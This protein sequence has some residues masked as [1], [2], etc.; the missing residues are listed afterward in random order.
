MYYEISE[1]QLP[2]LLPWNGVTLGTKP[3]WYNTKPGLELDIPGL[4]VIEPVDDRFAAT[5]DYEYYCLL[6]KLSHYDDDIPHELH[7]IV[8]EDSGT[9]KGPHLF[10]ERFDVGNDLLS[11][12]QVGMR[13]MR[14]P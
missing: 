11:R 6:S 3:M 13:C 9:N 10:R 14:N 8:K 7:E 12:M 1:Q 2:D 5:V 4:R